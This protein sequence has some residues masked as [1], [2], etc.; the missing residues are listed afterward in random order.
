[1][2]LYILRH[3]IA[4]ERGTTYYLNDD[5]P[6]TPEG[7]DKMKKET[8]C[9]PWLVKNIDIIFSS[10]LSR[11]KET[12]LLA[13]KALKAESNIQLIDQLLPGAQKEKLFELL[14]KQKGKENIMLVGHEPDLSSIV[15]S[16]LGVENSA[17]E[18]KKGALC[19]IVIDGSV[20]K[21]S[22]RMQWLMQPKQLR[23]LAGN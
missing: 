4:V 14:N 11:A 5:R 13:A 20:Q 6:L 2:N 9:F 18:L 19:L 1:M 12:A 16:L 22:G 15:C 7:I 17:V 3:A 8:E 23:M 10:P 21:G